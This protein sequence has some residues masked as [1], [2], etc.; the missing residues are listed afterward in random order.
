MSVTLDE[1]IVSIKLDHGNKL[2]I[3]KYDDGSY[4]S[5]FFRGGHVSAA[6]SREETEVVI[7]AL[8]LALEAA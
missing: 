1:N 8:Q 2:M 3:D 6:M 7:Q 5:I 4:L